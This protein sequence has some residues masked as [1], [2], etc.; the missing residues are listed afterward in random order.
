MGQPF[1]YWVFVAIGYAGIT[2][3]VLT[4]QNLYE[5]KK[6]A[7]LIDMLDSMKNPLTNPELITHEYLLF[8]RDALVKLRGL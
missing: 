6:R 2:L 3:L 8:I 4:L 1:Y 5:Q 7:Y